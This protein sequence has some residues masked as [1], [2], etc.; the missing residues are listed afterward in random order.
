MEEKG[1]ERQSCSPHKR[2]KFLCLIN[3]ATQ[4]EANKTGAIE[5]SDN[6]S[7]IDCSGFFKVL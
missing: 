3:P 1:T 5:R 7:R 2:R 4:R 6:E